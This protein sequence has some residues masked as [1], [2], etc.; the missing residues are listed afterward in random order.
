MDVIRG[1]LI[2]TQLDFENASLAVKEGLSKGV[3]VFSIV[4]TVGSNIARLTVIDK[5]D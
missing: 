5:S 1:I 2:F 3:P 4:N